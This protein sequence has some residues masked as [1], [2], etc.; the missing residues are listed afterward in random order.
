M[1][2]TSVIEVD[3]EIYF[4]RENGL[5]NTDYNTRPVS[6]SLGIVESTSLDSILIDQ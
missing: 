4:F 3:S 1:G 6:C 2:H 5:S